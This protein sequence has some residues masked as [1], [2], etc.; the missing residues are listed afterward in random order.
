MFGWAVCCIYLMKHVRSVYL[1]YSYIS[2][3]GGPGCGTTRWTLISELAG[4]TICS[5]ILVLTIVFFL[6][7]EVCPVDCQ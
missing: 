4:D 1:N 6:L 2:L 3:Q 5:V 7:P